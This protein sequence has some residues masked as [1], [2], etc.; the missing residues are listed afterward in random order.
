MC[1]FPNTHSFINVKAKQKEKICLS[2]SVDT[3]VDGLQINI[4]GSSCANCK[5]GTFHL[6]PDNKDGCLSCFCMGVTQLCSSSTYYRDLVR[7]SDLTT[8]LAAGESK[9]HFRHF[10]TLQHKTLPK[11]STNSKQGKK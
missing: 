2:Q 4:E 6:S 10:L 5:S 7:P 3:M 11:R 8:L 9:H 1:H